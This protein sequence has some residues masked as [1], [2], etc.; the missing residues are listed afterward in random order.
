MSRLIDSFP[1]LRRSGNGPLSRRG[2]SGSATKPLRKFGKLIL[3]LRWIFI[4]GVFLAAVS[5]HLWQSLDLPYRQLFGEVYYRIESSDKVVALTFDDGPDPLYTSR[6][7]EVL[8]RNQIKA[9][10]FMLGQSI[11]EYPKVAHDVY[12]RGH[13]LGNHSYS[14]EWMVFKSL[15]FVRSE[16]DST[17]LLLRGLGVTGDIHFRSPYG[18]QL[19]SV[20]VILWQLGKKNILFDVDPRDWEMQDPLVLAQRILDDAKPG[21]IILLHDGGGDRSG[22]VR[23]VEVII[24]ELRRRGFRFITVSELLAHAAK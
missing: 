14:H 2:L 10:F 23:T 1:V 16:I 12:R 15:S 22:T 11:V 18:A 17:D 6:V 24:P 19:F 5:A 13:E 21:S 8:D 20:P 9:T 3:R 7:L 4:T